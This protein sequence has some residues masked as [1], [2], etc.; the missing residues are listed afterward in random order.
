M[1]KS[2]K[3]KS[4]VPLVEQVVNMSKWDKTATWEALAARAISEPR[5]IV[6]PCEREPP[7]EK[8]SEKT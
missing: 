4:R 2:R 8:K 1:N 3:R 7:E 5:E 6:A